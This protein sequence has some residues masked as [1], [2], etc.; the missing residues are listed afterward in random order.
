MV[1][2]EGVKNR[3][4]KSGNACNEVCEYPK[5]MSRVLYSG[6]KEENVFGLSDKICG[7]VNNFEE[8]QCVENKQINLLKMCVGLHSDRLSSS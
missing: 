6:K 5:G 8:P 2:E 3:C 4:V 7:N 1:N